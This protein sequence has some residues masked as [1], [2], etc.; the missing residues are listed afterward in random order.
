MLLLK[1]QEL[2]SSEYFIKYSNSWVAWPGFSW[3]K[4]DRPQAMP[5][6]RGVILFSNFQGSLEIVDIRV[7]ILDNK[8]SSVLEQLLHSSFKTGD[9]YRRWQQLVWPSVYGILK[10]V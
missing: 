2:N 1:V 7:I 8:L 9:G 3:G 4:R 10:I 6:V 5:R